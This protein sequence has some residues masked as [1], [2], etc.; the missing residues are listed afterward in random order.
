[1]SDSSRF[2]DLLGCVPGVSSSQ[3]AGAETGAGTEATESDSEATEDGQPSSASIGERGGSGGEI[4]STGRI[5]RSGVGAG[6][7]VEASSL[8]ELATPVTPSVIQAVGDPDRLAD[9]D[10][11]IP[12]V[13]DAVQGFLAEQ[14]ESDDWLWNSWMT[15][16]ADNRQLAEIIRRDGD[17]LFVMVEGERLADLG[18]AI[19]VS[20][21]G[22]RVV[23]DVHAGYAE[24]NGLVDYT[25]AMSVLCIAVPE[26][27]E[28]ATTPDGLAD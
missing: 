9:T 24:V 23:R 3:N 1:M 22:M 28:L 18:D 14:I 2:R 11:S 19:E 5:G 20:P 13:L 7:G 4:P 12:E 17:E 16:F 10:G 26:D 6:G 27:V 25:L 8:D 15:A 21:S